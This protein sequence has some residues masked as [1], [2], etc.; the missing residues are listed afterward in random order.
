MVTNFGY[1]ICNAEPAA[2]SRRETA[3]ILNFI[4]SR[5]GARIIFASNR[6]GDWDIYSQPADGRGRGNTAQAALRQYPV[7]ILADGTLLYQEIHPKTG[8]DLGPIARWE[9]LALA[10][11]PFQRRVWPI[12]AGYGRTAPGGLIV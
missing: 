2:A 12:L 6:G 4:W 10:G 11:D 3:T 9:S 7:S 8:R 5:D 1:M